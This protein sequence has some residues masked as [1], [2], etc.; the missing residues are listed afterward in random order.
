MDW[1]R[2]LT[3]TRPDTGNSGGSGIWRGGG[4]DRGG[5]VKPERMNP[6]DLEGRSSRLKR[7]TAGVLGSS[8]SS[9]ELASALRSPEESRTEHRLPEVFFIA[10]LFTADGHTCTNKT[11]E[12]SLR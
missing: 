3:H 4:A 2:S 5:R 1:E 12:C 11:S 6:C 8:S 10:F 9:K 7:P